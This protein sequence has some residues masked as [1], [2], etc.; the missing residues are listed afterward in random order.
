[1]ILDVY[2]FSFCDSGTRGSVGATIAAAFLVC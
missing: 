1:M 2:L